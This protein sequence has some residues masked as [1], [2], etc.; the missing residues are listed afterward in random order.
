MRPSAVAASEAPPQN[1]TPQ[2]D[3][4]KPRQL[5]DLRAGKNKL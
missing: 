4:L 2:T 3:K 5:L 1:S